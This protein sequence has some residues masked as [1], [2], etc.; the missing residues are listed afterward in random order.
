MVFVLDVTFVSDAPY[1]DP[2]SVTWRLLDNKQV[3]QTGA[4]NVEKTKGFG[5]YEDLQRIPCADPALFQQGTLEVR[6][7]NHAHARDL[8]W[9]ALRHWKSKG[10]VVV[11]ARGGWVA[12]SHFFHAMVHDN[13]EE[14]KDEP[15][16]VMDFNSVEHQAEI[17]AICPI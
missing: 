2:Q 10:R 13:L 7:K 17:R 1:T 12:W 9:R 5:R 3:V 14:R 11:L 16:E 8:F 6:C 15:L 4:L